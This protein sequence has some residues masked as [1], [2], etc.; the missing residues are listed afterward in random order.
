MIR[1]HLVVVNANTTSSSMQVQ[2][3]TLRLKRVRHQRATRDKHQ[4]TVCLETRTVR[5]SVECADEL[6]TR[7][8]SIRYVHVRLALDTSSCPIC[9]LGLRSPPSPLT[10]PIHLH[11]A[12]TLAHPTPQ[13]VT[14]TGH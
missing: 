4:S 5:A 2:H 9:A 1:V 3:V 11:P 7:P 6:L 12:T 13:R 14:V 8:S 10:P